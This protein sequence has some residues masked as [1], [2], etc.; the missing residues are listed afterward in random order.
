MTAGKPITIYAW[1]SWDSQAVRGL[2]LTP[3]SA[4]ADATKEHGDGH[5]YSVRLTIDQLPQHER[6]KDADP[7]IAI[8]SAL[9]EAAKARALVVEKKKDA[10]KVNGQTP[11][12]SA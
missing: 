6:L 7:S 9:R 11:E 4:L 3:Q 2:G 12:K 8:V 5:G 10:P 1:V